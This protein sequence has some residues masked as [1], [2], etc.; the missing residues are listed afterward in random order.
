MRTCNL[1]HIHVLLDTRA[2]QHGVTVTLETRGRGEPLHE[3]HTKHNNYVA[4]R[5]IAHTREHAN[6][7]KSTA[8]KWLQDELGLGKT[9]A[10]YHTIT[11][12]THMRMS[13]NWAARMTAVSPLLVFNG[14][15]SAKAIIIA[16]IRLACA[17]TFVVPGQLNRL[18]R[19][20]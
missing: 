18:P 4:H 1:A 13:G 16:E 15:L 9:P 10:E 14:K 19:C 17:V 8:S 11:R 3:P 7:I 2:F 12:T 20:R 6:A 5:R